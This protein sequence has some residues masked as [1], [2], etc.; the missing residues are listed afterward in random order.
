MNTLCKFH[1][2]LAA[3]ETTVL[4][5]HTNSSVQANDLAGSKVFN[6]TNYMSDK[7]RESNTSHRRA[8]SHYGSSSSRKTTNSNSNPNIPKH[9]CSVPNR[10][11]TKYKSA[12][13]EFYKALYSFHPKL[14]NGGSIM[15]KPPVL[16]HQELDLYNFCI[17]VLKCG[18]FHSVVENEGTWSRIF[19]A[20]PNYSKTE[21]S[22][23]YRLKRI[24]Q[25]F[26]YDFETTIAKG[27]RITATT[28]LGR[29]LK[30]YVKA[31]YGEA[32]AV[33]E[34]NDDSEGDED[35]D[36]SDDEEEESSD[37]E[38]SSESEDDN[39]TSEDDAVSEADEESQT[40]SQRL[41]EGESSRNAGDQKN[42]LT[43]QKVQAESPQANLGSNISIDGFVLT[44]LS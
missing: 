10:K 17:L 23:S 38:S 32:M 42:L 41:K 33:S 9:L 12:K 15:D 5:Q 6:Y 7:N 2:G 30:E 21:T 24:Y 35:E 14:S 25:K 11:N 13:K 34:L 40:P 1:F 4:P 19:K 26:L 22:A 37:E 39:E 16:A 31:D 28:G 3:E 44:E 20:L 36:S 27:S 18:G 43:L 29:V 8:S